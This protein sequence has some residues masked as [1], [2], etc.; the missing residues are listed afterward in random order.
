MDFSCK[1]KD[2][3]QRRT[4]FFGVKCPSY[5]INIYRSFILGTEESTT[6]VEDATPEKMESIQAEAS[7]EESESDE[8]ESDESE[9]D[10]AEESKPTEVE[11]A[12][13]DE[14][15]ETNEDDLEGMFP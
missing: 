12:D 2:F 15:A 10:E 14:A 6:S 7:P 9:S 3:C 11:K 5:R 8:S 4:R 1:Q 13:S